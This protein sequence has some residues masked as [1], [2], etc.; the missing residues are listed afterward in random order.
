VTSDS[1]C[2]RAM[3]PDTVIG[4]IEALLR[5]QASGAQVR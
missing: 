5:G 1:E 4:A 3:T 2:L